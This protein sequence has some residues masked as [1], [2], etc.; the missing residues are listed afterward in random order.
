MALVENWEALGVQVADRVIYGSEE[1]QEL[2]A[3][4]S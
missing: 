3:I 1:D 2:L 4:V